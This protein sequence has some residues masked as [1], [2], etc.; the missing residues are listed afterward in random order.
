MK[1]ARFENN[2]QINPDAEEFLMRDTAGQ[3]PLS[4][5]GWSE[6]FE[7]QLELH[8]A[9][10]APSRIA[11]V[12]RARVSATSQTGTAE[13]TLPLPINTGDF[14]VGDWVLAQPQTR[15]VHRRLA[16]KTVLE[17]RN[18]GNERPQ[19]AAANVDK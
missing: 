12:H 8:G 10:L 18:Q 13:L 9:N 15:L 16:R 7:D 3:M 14:A 17:R 6:F 4:S 5:L 2:E 1:A 19:L 11:T